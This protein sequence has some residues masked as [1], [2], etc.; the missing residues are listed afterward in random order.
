VVPTYGSVTDIDAN[1]YQTVSYANKEW[2]TENLNTTH[3]N[4]GTLIPP[5]CQCNTNNYTCTPRWCYY[6]EDI[7]YSV[8]YGKLYVGYTM[9]SNNVCPV[10]WHVST[11]EDWAIIAELFAI[12]GE[13][14]DYDVSSNTYSGTTGDVTHLLEDGSNQSYLSL[15]LYGYNNWDGNGNGMGSASRWLIPSQY[16]TSSHDFVNLLYNTTN[17]YYNLQPSGGSVYEFGY[18]RCVKD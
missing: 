17:G 9:N 18:I 3:Y 5:N 14:W 15:G 7:Q 6:N 16:P 4:D 12:N 2:M 11:V 13:G 8:G 10:G 1:T